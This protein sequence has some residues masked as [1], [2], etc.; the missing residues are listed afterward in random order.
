MLCV[1]GEWVVAA[2]GEVEGVERLQPPAPLDV[3]AD[4]EVLVVAAAVGVDGTEV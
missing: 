1:G 4:A 2:G 3:Q